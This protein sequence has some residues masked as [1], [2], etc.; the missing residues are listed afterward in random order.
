MKWAILLWPLLAAISTN[1]N[2]KMESI[3]IVHALVASYVAWGVITGI[4]SL[5]GTWERTGIAAHTNRTEWY[6]WALWAVSMVV[7]VFAWMDRDIRFGRYSGACFPAR[8]R[9]LSYVVAFFGIYL[10]AYGGGYF[11]IPLGV[12]ALFAV[13]AISG[14]MDIQH[15]KSRSD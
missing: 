9:Q 15:E 10:V 8:H 5:P 11:Y 6:G 13:G 12:S 14:G 4:W 3:T 1:R 7:A 2:M